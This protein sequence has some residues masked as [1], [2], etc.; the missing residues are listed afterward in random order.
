[1]CVCVC[2]SNRHTVHADPFEKIFGAGTFQ[3]TALSSV[4]LYAGSRLE[5]WFRKG[6]DNV[7]LHEVPYPRD[8]DGNKLPYGAILDFDKV[9]IRLNG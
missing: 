2:C 6:K 4:D 1:M 5:K 7:L 9:P 8:V 3:T